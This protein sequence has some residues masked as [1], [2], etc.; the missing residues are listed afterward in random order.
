MKIKN[1]LIILATG[2]SLAACGNNNDNI[3]DVA[4]STPE[5]TASEILKLTITEASAGV[6]LS[7]FILPSS[8]DF[9]NIPQDLSNPITTE[10]VALG[11]MLYH[12]TALATEGVNE[13]LSGTWS[14]A[15]CHHATSGFKA[16]IPQGIGEGGEG[17]GFT[18]ESRVL[19]E[20][21]DKSSVDPQF[22]PD[23]QPL[24]SPA[25]LNVAYQDVMLWNGQFGNAVDGI[26]NAGIAVEI[27]STQGTPKTVNTRQLSGVESQAIAGT[28]VHRLNTSDNSIVQ[29]NL[30]YRV[31]FDA[32]F[33]QGTEDA[34][35][36][37]GKAIAAFERTILANQAPFQMYLKGEDEAMT[38]DEI[39]GATLFFG[40]AG[41]VGCH[42]GPGLSS[43]VRATEEEM[44]FSIGFADFD[45]NNPQITGTVT[46]ADSRGRGGFTGEAAD[47]Y[48][49]KVPQ[50]YNL[51][52]TI[53][54]GHG[55]SFNSIRDVI[56]YKN[57]SVAQKVLPA[58]TLDP[59]FVALNLTD[60]E[61]DQ[62][63]TFLETGLYDPNLDRYVPSIL[64]SGNCPVVN[65]DVA[66]IDLG[67]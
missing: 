20:G 29:T 51:A 53:V 26:V 50:L 55:A 22:I 36:D 37:A 65:D 21:F 40:K 4:N 11:Q 8:D 66:K 45:I 35:E 57:A 58:S 3:D 49:F 15:S 56:A 54:F 17:F 63:T 27:L 10:K 67:C 6:G 16:G 64:P 62:L 9:D 18:G 25:V 12:E 33:P 24:T 47:D 41:C 7:A 38:V 59:R 2:L 43:Y 13:A 39:K 28:G 14:C 5:L 23:V 34:T 46:D 44:F 48:K 32:A 60:E 42:A 1:L 19:A 61:I 52:D 31:L 30:V